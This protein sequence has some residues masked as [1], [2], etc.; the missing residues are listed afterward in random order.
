MSPYLILII[1]IALEVLGTVLLPASHQFSKIL[2]SIVIVLSYSFSFYLLALLTDKLPLAV[3]YASWSGIGI[4][5]ITLLS[6]ILYNQTTN[7][8][9]IAGLL[10]I[11]I[12]VTMVNVYKI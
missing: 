1:S 4:F 8:T 10:L 11:V 12:G 5:S 6:Y 3:I 9:S 7:W 2:P